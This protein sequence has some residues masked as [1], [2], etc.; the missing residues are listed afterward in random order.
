MKSSSKHS[1]I[2]WIAILSVFFLITPFAG[3]AST[4]S[5]ITPSADATPIS[6]Q[7]YGKG[8]VTLLFV[9]GWSCD[10]R[11]WKEQ[12]PYFKK[13]Y[14]TITLD[15][16]GHGHSGMDRIVYT[17]QSFGEDVK[18]VAEAAESRN[19]I[20]IGHSMG[21]AVAA[22]AARLMPDRVIGIIGVDTLGN[23]EY[24][25][26]EADRMQMT[27][28]LKKNFR[29]ALQNFVGRMIAKDASPKIQNWIL[30]DMSSAPPRVAISAMHE[31][32][33]QFITGH[34]AKNFE[35]LKI[36]VISVNADLMPVNTKGNR[37]HMLSYEAMIIRNAGHFLMLN[38]PKECNEALE[39]AIKKI[40]EK[41]N[42]NS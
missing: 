1:T 5:R 39:K 2:Y 32:I 28:P 6:F 26:S 29:K 34:A 7:E 10:S 21:G 25:W 13:E 23:V 14:T 22:E 15:L 12:I 8:P 33:G 11:Y 37:R 36:P 41:K 3:A 4:D 38:K 42:M 18:A 31:Y 19:I 17:M 27:D 16:A 40:A 35:S 9:H 30:Q 20:L 24:P